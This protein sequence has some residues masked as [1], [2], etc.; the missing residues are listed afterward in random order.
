MLTTLMLDVQ[1]M[2]HAVKESIRNILD[3]PEFPPSKKM[4]AIRNNVLNGKWDDA[5]VSSVQ[6]C[7][8]RLVQSL[9]KEA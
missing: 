7:E 3:N 4:E 6:M 5:L 9:G 8:H 1:R 2:T